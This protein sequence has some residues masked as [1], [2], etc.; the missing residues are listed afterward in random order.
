MTI[1]NWFSDRKSGCISESNVDMSAIAD[2]TDLLWCRNWT[3]YASFPPVPTH[4]DWPGDRQWWRRVE[5]HLIGIVRACVC[6]FLSTCCVCI[7]LLCVFLLFLQLRSPL[8]TGLSLKQ[9]VLVFLCPSALKHQITDS[10]Q[11]PTVSFLH[12]HSQKHAHIHSSPSP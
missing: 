12:T 3:S 10:G 4:Y 9:A 7:F 5:Y 1:V 2:C 6:A 8:S 11:T